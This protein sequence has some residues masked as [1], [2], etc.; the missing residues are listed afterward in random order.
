ML[1][2]RRE[3]YATTLAQETW[4][5]ETSQEVSG[6]SHGVQLAVLGSNRPLARGVL[7]A[8]HRVLPSPY[9]RLGQERIIPVDSEMDRQNAA[10]LECV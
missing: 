4:I 7:R 2:L 6:A 5:V 1:G 10:L 9:R 3:D 8:V